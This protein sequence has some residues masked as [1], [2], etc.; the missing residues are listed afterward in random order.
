[1]GRSIPSVRMGSKEVSERWR[2]A[3]RALKKEDQDHGLWLAE[4]AKKHS[5]EAF[6]ALDDPLEAAVF[7]VLVEIVKELEEGRK[8]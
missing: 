4:M 8:E 6:Y 7:S 2:K 1:M 3:S 5:S